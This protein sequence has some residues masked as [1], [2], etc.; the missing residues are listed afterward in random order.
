MWLEYKASEIQN[1][2]TI[3]NMKTLYKFTK[4]IS[5]SKCGSRNNVLIKIKDDRVLTTKEE[6]NVD[7]LNIFRDSE[8]I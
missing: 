4:N 7:G 2:A 3:N 1:V 8:S 5:G 6:E